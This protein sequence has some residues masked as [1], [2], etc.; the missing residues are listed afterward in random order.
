MHRMHRIGLIRPAWRREMDGGL[1]RL[2]PAA[3][4]ETL[5]AWL[6]EIRERIFDE[7][8]EAPSDRP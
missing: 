2:E 7:P 8:E 5:A 4:D 1:P 6:A 3:P